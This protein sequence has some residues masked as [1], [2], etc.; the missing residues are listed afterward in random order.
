MKVCSSLI[1]L[2]LVALQAVLKRVCR[3]CGKSRLRRLVGSVFT[4][5]AVGL[6]AR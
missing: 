5:A 3:L 4:F 1:I 6:L 2:R